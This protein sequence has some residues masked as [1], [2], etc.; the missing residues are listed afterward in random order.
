MNSMNRRNLLGYAGALPLLPVVSSSLPLPVAAA[1]IST[2]SRRVRPSDPEWPDTPAWARVREAV[3]GNLI[4]VEPPLAGCITSAGDG[5][6]AALF[7]ALKN[8]HYIGDSAALT[9]TLGWVDA[10]T[11]KP[12]VYAVAAHGPEDVVAAVNFA[13]TNNLR[14][15]VKGGGHSYQGTSNAADSLLIWT[16]PMND[17]TVHDAFVASG[18]AGEAAQPAVTVGAGA[19]WM[20]V[21]DAV[22]T[23]SGR[24]VQGGGCAT[25]GVAGLIQGGGF[26]S[27]SKNYGLA[28]AGLL[29]AEV[30]TADGSVL[31]ANACTNPDLFWGLKGGGNSLGVITRLTLRTQDLPNQFGGVF[32]TVKAST[33]AAFRRLIGRFVG[34]YAEHLCDPHWGEQAAFLPTNAMVISMVFQGLDKPEA[35]AAWRPFLDWVTASPQDF[36]L[37]PAPVVLAAPA[38]RFWD[39]T[40]LRQLPGIVLADDR[41]GAPQ[42][43]VFW[44]GNRAEA[45]WFIHGYESAWLPMRLLR[46]GEQERLVDALFAASRHARLSLHFNKGLG[47]APA[48][49]VTLAEDTAVNPVVLDAFALAISASGGPPAY[50]GVPGHE[51]DARAGR[52]RARA[53]TRAMNAMRALV[54]DAG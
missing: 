5:G 39:P 53:N 31:I 3:G 38:R 26:G 28:A 35:G 1:G 40:F 52:E 32:L 15:V 14:L 13:R 22:T 7:E 47:G 33:D 24:Y 17:I 37:D 19:I 50:P 36:S 49:A 42:N 4:E 8:P 11:S 27:F 46:T 43:N 23:G 10:W 44:S 34:F 51:P 20:H 16:R 2:G 29:E 21:Y 41:P 45:G 54:P 25:V 48:D 18:C 30:V 9:Q 6:C 12:S